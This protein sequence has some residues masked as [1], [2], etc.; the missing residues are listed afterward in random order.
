MPLPQLLPPVKLKSAG[1]ELPSQGP[2]SERCPRASIRMAT[3]A[4]FHPLCNVL[5]SVFAF[6]TFI[7]GLDIDPD[8]NM[9]F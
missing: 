7:Q 5:N 2:G 9:N 6:F 8:V 1:F 4:L 3:S